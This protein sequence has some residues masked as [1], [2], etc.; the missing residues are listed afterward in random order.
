MLDALDCN[1]CIDLLDMSHSPFVEVDSEVI[2]V[3]LWLACVIILW[4][5]TSLSSGPDRYHNTSLAAY[6]AQ[7]GVRVRRD[8]TFLSLRA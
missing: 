2:A 4:T 3:D 7:C 1:E 6:P 5:T 8:P